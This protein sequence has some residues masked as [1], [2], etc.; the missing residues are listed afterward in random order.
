MTTLLNRKDTAKMFGVTLRT[1]DNWCRAGLLPFIAL[2][3]GKRFD[4]QDIERFINAR[5]R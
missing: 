1:V 5:R 4:L 3:G 2:P